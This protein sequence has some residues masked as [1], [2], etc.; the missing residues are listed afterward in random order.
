[1]V[2]RPKTQDDLVCPKCHVDFRLKPFGTSAFKKH[3]ARKNPC[4]P[5]E[6]HVY[7]RDRP[8]PLSNVVINDFDTMDLSHV[9]G[10]TV[11]GRKEP[12]IRAMLRQVFSVDKNKCIILKNKHD[13]PDKILV[14]RRGEI[15]EM[16]IH[17]L[18]I[19]TLLLM[20]TRLFP[21]LELC[22]W[23]KYTEFEEWVRTDSGVHLSDSNWQGTIEPLS[24][25][26]GTVRNF[27]RE[28]LFTME[29]KRNH[30]WVLAS[31]TV[32]TLEP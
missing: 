23:E 7:I 11:Q 31:S 27:L 12:W 21:Y 10:P 17:D 26:Y 13:Y 25:Y 14:K 4:V 9:S 22:G 32:K 3:M 20:H 8:K 1:M 28:Y 16:S 6:G 19:L 2:G 29:N 5:T 30:N 24:Y 15:K 18:T